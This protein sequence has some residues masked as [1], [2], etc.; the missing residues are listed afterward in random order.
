M[1]QKCIRNCS[2]DGRMYIAGTEYELSSEDAKSLADYF[3]GSP[4]KRSVSKSEKRRV[5]IQKK[6]STK[7]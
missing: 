6:S 5:A 2:C 3:E 1:K 4:K 7:K